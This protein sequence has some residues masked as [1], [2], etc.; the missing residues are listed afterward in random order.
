MRVLT[1]FS[2]THSV[3]KVCTELGWEEV[4]LDWA[5]PSTFNVNV[6]DW[7]YQSLYKPGHF[8]IVWAS[9]DCSQFSK[10]RYNCPRP[11]DLDTA[12]KGVL[13]T[14]EII[15]YLRPR[16]FFIENPET[17]L[18]KSREYMHSRPYTVVDYC[19]YGWCFRKR[20][21][22]WSNI[23]HELDALL[24]KCNK[25][26][27][28]FVDG[29]HVASIEYSFGGAKRGMIPPLLLHTIFSKVVELDKHGESKIQMHV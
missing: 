10:A 5:H 15:E 9:P 18:L 17:G 20:T 29:K 28:A 11:R 12:D 2:G 16:Y 13:K 7:D 19:M 8:D 25:Q 26:C 6:H 1:L 4:S 23:S 22:I 24:K 14:L 27:G 21:A 3:G